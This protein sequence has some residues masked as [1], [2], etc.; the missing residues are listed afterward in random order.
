MNME[1]I[2]KRDAELQ[3]HHPLLKAIDNATDIFELGNAL[4]DYLLDMYGD[5]SDGDGIK[6]EQLD[7]EILCLINERKMSNED[8]RLFA[9]RVYARDGPHSIHDHRSELSRRR[10]EQ[11]GRLR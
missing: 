5:N 6:D 3:A 10:A 9:G 1:D 7:F 4:A 11:Q 2:E 8:A